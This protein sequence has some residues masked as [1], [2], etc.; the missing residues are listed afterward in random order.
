MD[1]DYPTD[2]NESECCVCFALYE[3]DESGKDWVACACGR[4]LH[5]DCTDDCVVDSKGNER[6]FLICLIVCLFYLVFFLIV[7]VIIV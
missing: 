1:L 3:D 6:L 5:E 7:T 2:F 4:W